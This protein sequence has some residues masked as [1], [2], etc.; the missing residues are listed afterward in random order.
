MAKTYRNA[1]VA[2]VS[3]LTMT[4]LCS[5]LLSVRMTTATAAHVAVQAGGLVDH[6]PIVVT[7][8]DDFAALGFPG[9]GTE[10]DPYVIQGLR[11]RTDG[12]A[13]EV[14]D[15]TAYFVVRGCTLMPETSSGQCG[16]Q[17][18]QV[19][20]FV[21]E[22][23]NITGMANGIT[24]VNSA[25]TGPTAPRLVRNNTVT[26]C[27][28]GV[29][30][31]TGATIDENRIERC[32]TGIYV[33]EETGLNI[34][35]NTLNGCGLVVEA[36][37]LD[38]WDHNV[39]GN[40]VNGKPLGWLI[41]LGDTVVDMSTYGQVLAAD[42]HGTT[43]ENG[44]FT[45]AP[46]QLA[47]STGCT[48]RDMN[49]TGTGITAVA[50]NLRGTSDTVV[51]NT[52]VEDSDG[53]GVWLNECENITLT[54]SSITGCERTGLYLTQSQGCKVTRCWILDNGDTGI[55]V[56]YGGSHMVWDN[57]I[58]WN[59]RNAEDDSTDTA[60][61]DGVSTGNAWSDY[62]PS[63]ET[64]RVEGQSGS[65]DHYPRL[66]TYLEHPR[67]WHLGATQ[68]SYVN[69]TTG[70]NITWVAALA[71]PDHYEIYRDGELIANA[72]LTPG[73][74]VIGVDG[75]APGTYTYTVVIFDSSGE[76]ANDTVYVMVMTPTATTTTTYPTYTTTTSTSTSTTVTTT[77]TSP[78]TNTTTTSGTGGSTAADP[79][80]VA[81]YLGA[82]GAGILLLGAAVY[83][84]RTKV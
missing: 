84:L 15:T 60:W 12:I 77:A 33:S 72:S 62:D 74:L 8:D 38:Y 45:G 58:G 81:V 1:M 76:Q 18:L 59:R 28:R 63:E 20:T 17:L 30:A 70:N 52:R 6:P 80:V 43:F 53:T 57:T 40:T 5:P 47:F 66:I 68:L 41:G 73:L 82:I 55:D 42:C 49:V 16:V 14:R 24:I 32:G 29:M 35:G 11:I 25:G 23:C 65:V 26:D 54:G 37:V 83:I 56:E 67:V 79:A 19:A 51:N 69:G 31:M 64:Y 61:D 48:I 13:I 50:L 27:D 78:Y 44:S 71:S 46:F 2:V 21:V 34:G 36:H 7:S 22:D 75:L 3:V 39:T 4:V 9:S 10:G